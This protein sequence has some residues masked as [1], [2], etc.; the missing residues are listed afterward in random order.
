MQRFV[1]FIVILLQ[2]V[3]FSVLG[4]K[5]LATMEA[6]R[7]LFYNDSTCWVQFF[8]K[9]KALQGKDARPVKVAHFGGSHVQ[10]GVWTNEFLSL[11]Q[12][13]FKTTGGGY[14]AFPYTI[15]R[16]NGQPYVDFSSG[17]NWKKCRAV[18]REYCL[19]LGV[20]GMSASTN[21]SLVRV[22]IRLTDRSVCRRFNMLKM[23]HN[24]N[25]SFT[26]HLVKQPGLETAGQDFP[27]KGFSYY[28]FDHFV[29]SIQLEVV[30]KD[31]MQKDFTL[32]GFSIENT[33]P[34]FYC[35]G[36][37]VNGASSSSYLKCNLFDQQLQ[38]LV[39]DMAIISLGV[40][41]V[42]AKDFSKEEFKANYDTLIAKL[43]RANP[44]MAILLTTTTD[45]YVKRK[46]PN[47]RTIMAQQAFFELGAKH[48][49]AVWDMF[50]VMGGYRSINKWIKAGYARRDRVHFS[51]AGYKYLGQLMYEA[52]MQS[53]NRQQQLK[54][55]R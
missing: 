52:F 20:N 15:T 26:W 8:D 44:D 55:H 31:T 14:F 33:E 37:G 43:K 17:S 28:G 12:T 34:G 2:S 54:P 38:S 46:T 5:G 10:A 41:D 19:P 50:K 25:T 7:F 6:N 48:H 18:Q 51:G 47:K 40:N 3:T 29:D 30:R 21:D 35:A 1:L 53:Y 11:L 4:Q 22:T 36:L 49:V 16:T 45:N 23:Y 24:F 42:Q 39:P 27:D 13:T 32:F 9:C